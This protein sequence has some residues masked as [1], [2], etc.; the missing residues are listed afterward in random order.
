MDSAVEGLFEI[1]A[2]SQN[3]YLDVP[4]YS[5]ITARQYYAQLQLEKRDSG[6]EMDPNEPW[7]SEDLTAHVYDAVWV[8]ALALNKTLYETGFDL[9]QFQYRSS[10]N[11]TLKL[12]QNMKGFVCL[13]E[14]FF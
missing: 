11:F 8:A 6:F 9:A 12:L 13:N 7:P 2:A 1:G 10:L 5:G 4:T 14:Q 3:P